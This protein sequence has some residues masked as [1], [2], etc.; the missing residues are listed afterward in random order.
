MKKIALLALLL[1]IASPALA[2][3]R[4]CEAF[5]ELTGSA[6]YSKPDGKSADW[7]VGGELLFP[8][9]M[10]GYLFV[11]PAVAI[12][13]GLHDSTAAGVVGEFVFAGV[14]GTFVG[15]SALYDLDSD[16]GKHRKHGKHT[17]AADDFSFAARAGFKFATGR[18]PL[19]RNAFVKVYAEYDDDDDLRGVGAIGLRF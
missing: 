9:L 10:D 12:R 14:N 7:T 3:Q 11:G 17:D 16:N 6:S 15:A 4:K 2:H 18:R 1:L 13:N 5:P 19:H 8:L